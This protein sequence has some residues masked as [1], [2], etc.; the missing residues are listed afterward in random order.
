[1]HLRGLV[2]TATKS[3]QMCGRDG[4]HD[5]RPSLR[6]IRLSPPALCC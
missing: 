3:D 4:W 6:E 2:I 1:M 5:T